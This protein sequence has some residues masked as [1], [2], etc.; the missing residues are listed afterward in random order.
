MTI[1]T[2]LLALLVRIIMMV[3]TTIVGVILAGVALIIGTFGLIF[4]KFKM[5]KVMETQ[6]N[7]MSERVKQAQERNSAS[8]NLDGKTIEV[9]EYEIVEDD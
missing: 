4:L 9:D 2:Q 3:T 6:F 5:G 7:E 1:L 8:K